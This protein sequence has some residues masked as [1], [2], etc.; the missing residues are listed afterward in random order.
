MRALSGVCMLIHMGSVKAG[1]SHQISGEMR[2]HPV[3]NHPDSLLMHVVHKILEI[4]RRPVPAGRRIISCHLVPPGSVQGMLHNRKKLH[5]GIPHL[6]YILRQLFGNLSVIV[7]LA[8]CNLLPF[9]I[10]CNGL[11]DP[12]A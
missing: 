12:G 7:E 11:T 8:T 10:N 4:L 1:K 5:M 6:V 3:K 2:W 9:L